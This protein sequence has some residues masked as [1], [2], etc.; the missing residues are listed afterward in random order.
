V[1]LDVAPLPS[2]IRAV[3]DEHPE[4]CTTAGERTLLTGFLDRH[5]ETVVRKWPG[6]P[7]S[8]CARERCPPPT[9]PCSASCG[10][11]GAVGLQTVIVSENPAGLHGSVCHLPG[12]IT[13]E[14]LLPGTKGSCPEQLAALLLA[15][16]SLNHHYPGPGSH[17]PARW[18]SRRSRQCPES[19][20]AWMAHSTANAHLTRQ[21]K[22]QRLSM[23]R[24]PSAWQDTRSWRATGPANRSMTSTSGWLP[25][26]AGHERLAI[27]LGPAPRGK[28]SR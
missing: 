3:S 12:V 25:Q 26:G 8:S 14:L 16:R 28:C 20:W 6:S 5:R 17:P 13:L 24:S 7:T 23:P 18:P 9:S 19:L 1:L 15:A 21:G 11:G 22:R 4:P 2:A 27:G 10:R